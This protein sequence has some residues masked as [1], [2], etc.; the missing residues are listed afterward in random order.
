MK[1]D[2]GRVRPLPHTQPLRTLRVRRFAPRQ[3]R[4]RGGPEAAARLD[5]TT[6]HLRAYAPPAHT[7]AGDSIPLE[8]MYGRVGT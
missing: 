2:R 8:G 1:A 4:I 7:N 5:V 6:R 3:Q